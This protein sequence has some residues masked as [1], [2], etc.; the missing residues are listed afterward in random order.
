MAESLNL[1]KKIAIVFIILISFYLIFVFLRYQKSVYESQKH[2]TSIIGSGG[3]GEG[4][5][6]G[7]GTSKAGFKEGMKTESNKTGDNATNI[8]FMT[9]NDTGP[10]VQTIDASKYPNLT[11]KD[12]VIKS[13][14]NT[15]YIGSS[16]SIHAISYALKRG[17]R[18][19]DFEVYLVDGLPCVGY[20]NSST[21]LMKI[22]S[23]N[24]LPLGQVLYSL[25]TEGFMAP[26]PN[27][28]DPLFVNL[29]INTSDSVL[30]ELVA[31]SVNKNMKNILYN[32]KVDS[33]TKLSD[34]MGK[35]VL[36][37]DV[38]TSPNYDSY[39]DCSA[40]V[41][42]KSE[43]FNLSQYVNLEIGGNSFR[44]ITYESLLGQTTNPVNINSDDET[45]DTTILRIAYPDIGLDGNPS[46]IESIIKDYG[47][48]FL[49]VRLY[50]LDTNLKNYETF[51]ASC[52]NAIVPF[53]SA[54][55]NLNQ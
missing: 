28:G 18:F 11:L 16:M 55:S 32:G 2:I 8:K 12:F 51:F 10:K 17:Y 22:S 21:N 49:A 20:G 15:A 46:A 26:T 36:S 23:S 53:S 5:I 4:F 38:T 3:S 50:F 40:L 6:A 54:I 48:Q 33:S 42:S 14:Y 47:T 29:R 35:I 13:S 34:I 45:S 27:T 52:G 41:N 30:Y 43:C 39:P 1:Y 19:V 9:V 7:M 37:I 44:K 24:T 31:K 25:V